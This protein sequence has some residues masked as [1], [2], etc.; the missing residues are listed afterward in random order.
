V[1]SALSLISRVGTL[2]LGVGLNTAI[3]SMVKVVLLDALPYHDT[4]RLVSIVYGRPEVDYTIADEWRARSKSF[5][6]MSSYRD[7]LGVLVDGDDAEMLRGLRVSYDFF[8]TLGVK[9]ELGRTFRLEEDQPGRRSEIILSHGLW[10]RRFG[11]DPH[12]VGRVLQLSESRLTVVGVLPAHFEPLIKATSE[13]SPEMYIPLGLGPGA[14]CC[15]D[16]RVLARLKPGVTVEQARAEMNAVARHIAQ[17]HAIVNWREAVLTIVPLHDQLFG[18]AQTALWAAMGAAFFVLLIACA[19]VASLTLAD[20]NGRAQEMATRAALG[21]SR[22][23]LVRQLLGE[24]LLVAFAGGVSGVLLALAG[25][26]ALAALAPAQI[27]RVHSARVDVPVLLVGLAASLITG[28]VF[29]LIPA[30]RTSKVDL[31]RALKTAGHTGGDRSRTGFQ[32]ALTIAE[33]ALAFVLMMGAGLMTKSVLRLM[34]IDLG[35]DPHNVLTL[36]TNVWSYKPA[37]DRPGYYQQVLDRLRATPGIE[38]AAFTSTIPMDQIDRRELIVDGRTPPGPGQAPLIEVASVT[39]NYFRLMRM[40]LIRGRLFSDQESPR[41]PGVVVISDTCARSQFPG[42][43]PIG[44]H[45]MLGEIVGVVGD[46]RMDS[47]DRAP[48]MQAY[49]P[50]SRI[51]NI[52][53]LVART[54]GDPHRME[55]AVRSAFL[56][57]DKTQPVYHVKALEDYVSSTVAERTFTFALLALF[58]GL[59]LVLGAVGIY[60]LISCSATQRTR[61]VGIRMALGAKRRDVVATV[62]RQALPLVVIG[63]ALGFV[64]SWMLTRLLASLLFEVRPTDLVTMTAVAVLLAFVSFAAS[65]VPAHHAASVDPVTALRHE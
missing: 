29:G 22:G 5:S 50:M 7:S 3:F 4:D 61:E 39:A 23:R 2:A 40:H 17:E 56:S 55:R 20:A 9:M 43:D 31:N 60:G 10:A 28:L 64:G 57:V 14:T 38:S 45:I 44:K 21:A 42:E 34:S 19:N 32:S 27:L 18:R 36:T 35:Y 30:W 49:T 65:Y 6:R 41:G 63:L 46:V 37:A 33:L 58:G 53:R 11:A 15:T 54:T 16:V 1:Q 51:P 59:S 26:G 12:I 47:L 48:A 62:L 25:T 52:A 8:D 13:L 24:N